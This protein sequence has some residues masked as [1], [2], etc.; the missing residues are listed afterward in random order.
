[1]SLKQEIR[2]AVLRSYIVELNKPKGH[3]YYDSGY[4]SNAER[5]WY[6]LQNSFAKAGNY[7]KAECLWN[8]IFV[9]FQGFPLYVDWTP[10]KQECIESTMLEF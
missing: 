5:E 2:T 8:K 9:S 10:E 7:L 4:K 6:K 1:M 3:C